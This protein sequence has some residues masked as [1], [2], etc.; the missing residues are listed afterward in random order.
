MDAKNSRTGWIIASLLALDPSTYLASKVDG[1]VTPA[2]QTPVAETYIEVGVE[3]ESVSVEAKE[4]TAHAESVKRP[5]VPFAPRASMVI[6]CTYND[7]ED[8]PCDMRGAPF[9]TLFSMPLE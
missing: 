3:P 8:Y 7:G 1:E 6:P 9:S 5:P 4:K 2:P